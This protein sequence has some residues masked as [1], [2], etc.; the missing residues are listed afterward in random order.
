MLPPHQQEH[1]VF[2]NPEP[3]PNPLQTIWHRL[4]GIVKMIMNPCNEP[5]YVWAEF[6]KEPAGQVALA[7][8]GLDMMQITRSRIRPKDSRSGGHMG[9]GRGSRSKKKGSGSAFFDPSDEFGRNINFEKQGLI[10]PKMQIGKTAMWMISDVVERGLWEFMVVDQSTKFVYNTML[11]VRRSE[12]CQRLWNGDGLRS[13]P[14]G[15]LGLL[16]WQGMNVF[17]LK[18]ENFPLQMPT[19]GAAMGAMW[20]GELS[21]QASFSGICTGGVGAQEAGMRIINAYTGEILADTGIVPT[22]TGEPYSASLSASAYPPCELRALLYSNLGNLEGEGILY[23]YFQGGPKEE[24]KPPKPQRWNPPRKYQHH[25]AKGEFTDANGN[26]WIRAAGGQKLK[27]P[28]RTTK[29][30]P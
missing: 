7:F 6:A 20:N 19:A 5:W 15:A 1:D 16:H 9:G 12:Y 13:G 2:G 30:K 8:L 4:N 25:K 28:R 11:G 17:S 10:E 3:T 26:T 14:T 24:P 22:F 18:Y 23:A 29:S 21:L 27:R